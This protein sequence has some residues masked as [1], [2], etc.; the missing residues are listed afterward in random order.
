PCVETYFGHFLRD[1]L[2]LELLARERG[3]PPL[4]FERAPWLHEQGYR[5]LLGMPAVRTRYARVNTLWLVDETALNAGWARRYGE[6]RRRIRE[7]VEPTGD[8]HVFLARGAMGATTRNLVNEQQL[9]EQLEACGFRI[10]R[11]E[12]MDATS[13]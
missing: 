7:K 5:N 1:A 13:I 11:P 6:L 10:I 9:A 3:L 2:P 12:Q 8:S 4:S